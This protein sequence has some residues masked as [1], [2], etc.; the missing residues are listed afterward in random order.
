MFARFF[1]LQTVSTA[2]FGTF[3]F[4]APVAMVVVTCAYSQLHQ[5]AAGL[6]MFVLVIVT[7]VGSYSYSHVHQIAAELGKFSVVV[8]TVVATYSN[9]LG[10]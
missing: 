7:T 9:S 8:V 6:G 4:A 5:T 1:G 2:E 3:V 10:Q